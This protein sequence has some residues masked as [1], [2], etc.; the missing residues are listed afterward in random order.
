MARFKILAAREVVKLAAEEK[1][2]GVVEAT[3]AM[4]VMWELEPRRFSAWFLINGF[5]L[6]GSAFAM[7]WMFGAGLLPKFFDQFGVVVIGS[8]SALMVGAIRPT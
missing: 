8:C 6:M 5:V 4:V 2:R 1:P 3:C 7:T